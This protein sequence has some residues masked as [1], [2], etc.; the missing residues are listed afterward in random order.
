MYGQTVVCPYI[1][2]IIWRAFSRSPIDNATNNLQLADY[3]GN[4]DPD[5]VVVLADSGY[6]DNRIEGAIVRKKWSFI[7]AGLAKL[8]R[9]I[10]GKAAL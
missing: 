7:R 10:S 3:I 9:C 1:N 8:D 6:D 2:I 5:E 4:H